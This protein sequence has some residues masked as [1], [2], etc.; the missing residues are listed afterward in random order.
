MKV[1]LYERIWMWLAAAMILGFVSAVVFAAGSHA[2]HPPSHMETVDPTQ[3]RIRGEF[4]EPRVEQRADGSVL[5]VGLAEMF[6]F[7]PN[8]L[9]VPAGRPVTFRLTS[10]D[11]IHGFEIVGTNVNATVVPGYISQTT[12]T[13]DR[14]GE[15][16]IVCNEYCG[17][18]HH[19]MQ[20]RLIVEGG[21]R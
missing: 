11:V 17:L 18:A 14:P 9:R 21:A 12:V 2:I 16:L 7:R 6:T 20:G 1:H 19:L 10:P 4:T 5:V 13:F 15:Y 3:V 8:T